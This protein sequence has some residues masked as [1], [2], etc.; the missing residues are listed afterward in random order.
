MRLRLSPHAGRFVSRG[1]AE[2]SPTAMFEDLYDAISFVWSWRWPTVNGRVTACGNRAHPSQQRKKRHVTTIAHLWFFDWRRR[3]LLWGGFLDSNVYH[4]LCQA[5]QKCKTEVSFRPAR[6]GSLPSRRSQR[7]STRSIRVG[8]PIK[9]KR[10]GWLASPF[11]CRRLLSARRTIR[12][13]STDPIS[14][15]AVSSVPGAR[16]QIESQLI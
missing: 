12:P 10:R 13:S 14:R 3:S 4:R 2:V 11:I 8:G 6:F 16:G 15:T 9:S 7:E 1:R 5:D